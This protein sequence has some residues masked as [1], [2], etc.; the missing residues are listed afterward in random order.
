MFNKSLDEFIEKSN[1]KKGNIV[2]FLCNNFKEDIHYTK[3]ELLR[4]ESIPGRPIIEYKLTEETYDLL[5]CTFNKRNRHIIDSSKIKQ[6]N[7]LTSLETQTIGFITQCFDG[8]Y[9]YFRQ[10]IIEKYRVDLCFETYKLIVECDENNHS[11]RYP[12]Y[13]DKREKVI[14]SKGYSF[15]RFDP[16]NKN[17][18]LHTL[19][20]TIHKFIIGQITDKI[21]MI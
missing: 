12:K 14:I 11:S 2:R 18:K 4:Y 16:N 5:N 3:I 1:S 10:Y 13:E 20:N 6:I 7:L 9:P 15:I 21:T 19:V 8:I 17:F